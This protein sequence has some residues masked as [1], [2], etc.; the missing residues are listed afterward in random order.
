VARG[1]GKPPP[2]KD[3]TMPGIRRGRGARGASDVQAVATLRDSDLSGAGMPGIGLRGE[4]P[5]PHICPT[6]QEFLL[7]PMCAYPRFLG[8]I[9]AAAYTTCECRHA[10]KRLQ[11]RPLPGQGP[12]P[13][14]AIDICLA[15]FG[16][17]YGLVP[18]AKG[19]ASGQEE[20]GATFPARV[21]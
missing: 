4:S 21:N 14:R 3:L 8:R 19:A 1:T 6:L 12:A 15:P 16:G 18:G 2:L 20:W 7:P 5:D 9:S 13:A 17:A 10:Q 11:D